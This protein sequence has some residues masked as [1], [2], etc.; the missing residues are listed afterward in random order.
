MSPIRGN[1]TS[2]DVQSLVFLSCSGLAVTARAV[3]SK[4]FR[5]LTFVGFGKW[6]QALAP[7]VFQQQ[8]TILDAQML[9]AEKSLHVYLDTTSADSRENTL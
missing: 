7:S 6:F 1:L 5:L 3:P 9:L 8:S 2:K 4:L